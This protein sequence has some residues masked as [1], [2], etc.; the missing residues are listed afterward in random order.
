LQVAQFTLTGWLTAA[1]IVLGFFRKEN[2]TLNTAL[3]LRQLEKERAAA[4]ERVASLDRA[5]ASL[6]AVDGR[7]SNGTGRRRTM[8][9]S[10]RRKIA[11]AQRRR[12]KLAKQEQRAQQR[13]KV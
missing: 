7:G 12:W 8:S 3:M 6:H 11:E 5:I 4:M 2:K 9:A 1:R 10:G 13:K